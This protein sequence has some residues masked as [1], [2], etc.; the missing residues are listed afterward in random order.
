ME[1]YKKAKAGQLAPLMQKTPSVSPELN[2]VIMK[3]MAADL[4][5]RYAQAGDVLNELAQLDH[6]DHDYAREIKDIQQRIHAR[7]NR[8]DYVCW[9][10]RKAMGRRMPKC[11]YCGEDQ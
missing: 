4:K 3:T 1:I 6:K 8:T 10:C 2:W 11:P 7:E 9:N 5:M